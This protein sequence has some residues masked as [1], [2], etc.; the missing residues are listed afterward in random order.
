M[1]GTVGCSKRVQLEV[2]GDPQ[3]KA[4]QGGAFG[5]PNGVQLEVL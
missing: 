1:R 3:L 4:R 5:G 2:F